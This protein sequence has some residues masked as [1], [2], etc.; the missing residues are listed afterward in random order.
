MKLL[1]TSD[2]HLRE[3]T[4]ICRTDDY[5][6]AQSEKLNYIVKF[7]YDNGCMWIDAGDVFDHWRPSPAL[8]AWTIDK[9]K[10]KVITI[11]GNHD[12]PQHNQ[13]LFHKS[14]LAVLEAAKVIN[15]TRYWSNTEIAIYRA[16]WGSVIPKEPNK[17]DKNK[18]TILIAHH[19]IYDK[20]PY[21]EADKDGTNV[22]KFL[23]THKFDLILTGHNHE[24]I[25]AW[26]QDTR[27]LINPGSMMRM[28][29]SQ[30]N[31][32]PCVY[33]FDTQSLIYTQIPL[34]YKENV[35]SREH[36]ELNEYKDSRISAFI[37]RLNIRNIEL[38]M[39]YK[40]NLESYMNINN[41]RPAIREIVMKSLEEVK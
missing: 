26:T 21:P 37:E 19:L 18:F 2:M 23:K 36:I 10:M 27:T 20:L 11:S 32:K 39:S 35:V 3:D 6:L 5:I 13:E 28:T 14:G 24:T 38:K 12:L 17:E 9:L 34:P 41:I 40:S 16:P 31:H 4:P 15:A 29:A 25:V 7:A 8:L 33:T 1:L 22:E 30:I